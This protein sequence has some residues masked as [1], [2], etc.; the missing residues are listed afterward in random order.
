MKNRTRRNMSSFY[1]N[2]STPLLQFRLKELKRIQF[3]SRD[4]A[5]K[6]EVIRTVL[7][8]RKEM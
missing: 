1:S 2:L 7:V 5:E 6:M 8:L 4:E 3:P